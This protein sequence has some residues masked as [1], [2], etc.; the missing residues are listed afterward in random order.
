[1]RTL[2]VGCGYVG[3]ALGAELVRQGHA[4]WGLRRNQAGEP[5]LREQGIQPLFADLTR[6]GALVGVRPDFDW[7]VH[8]MSASDSSTEAYRATYV[9][10]TRHLLAWLAPKPPA[11]LVYTSSTGVYGQNDGSTVTESSP[12]E[13]A[14]E[15][16]RVLLEA[17]RLLLEAARQNR[18]PAVILR[19][20]GI[21]GPGR[22]YWLRQFLSGEARLEGDGQRLLNMVHRDDVAGAIIAALERGEPG[23]IYNVADNEPVTQCE[24]FTWLSER[25][26]RPLP[27]AAQAAPRKRGV[28][29]KRIANERLR[30]E[31]R[32]RFKYPTFRE[33]YAAELERL[34]MR[35][36][37]E[38]PDHKED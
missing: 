14:A 9:E 23:E 16:G 17:E 6:P 7:V 32:Y 37:K 38:P 20:A 24:V 8:S 26:N 5:T 1:M 34:E 22:G 29:N 27:P 13:P 3:L 15:T 11:K 2:I 30:T 25:L 36:R 12:T 4:V 31:L 19:V 33:G 21:Y 35:N 28:T 10:A 18:C